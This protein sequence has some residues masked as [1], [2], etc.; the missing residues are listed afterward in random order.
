M[1]SKTIP[2]PPALP[3][4]GHAGRGVYDPTQAVKSFNLLE[5]KYGEIVRLNFLGTNVILCSSQRLANE[6][7]DEK[8]FYKD[9]RGAPLEL[10]RNAIGDGLLTAYYGE[11]SWG[12]AHRILMP[13]LGPLSI[14]AMF[15]SM[16][17]INSQLLKWERFGSD[18]AF[19]PTEEFSRLT[20]DTIALCMMSYRFNSFYHEHL[21]SKL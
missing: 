6:L 10:L 5:K 17:D 14:L 4:L 20:F 2:S 12:I 8:R 18:V 7:C 16:L 9:L 19:D 15:P 13:A 11:E 3:I 21:S 1:A